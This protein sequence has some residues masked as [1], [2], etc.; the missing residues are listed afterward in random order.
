MLCRGPDPDGACR[1]YGT[2]PPTVREGQRSP[3]SGIAS[4]AAVDL[5]RVTLCAFVAMM[6]LAALA[7]WWL[8]L[9]WLKTVL[10]GSTTMKANAA[11]G[12]L[13]L[14]LGQWPLRRSSQ[15]RP[16]THR[17]RKAWAAA[18]VALGVATLVEY[19]SGVRLGIDELLFADSVTTSAPYNGRMSPATALGLASLGAGS[20]LLWGVDRRWVAAAHW[21]VLPAV[22]VGVLS[23]T[24]YAYGVE[25]MYNFGPY[26]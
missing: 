4:S 25:R 8:G 1:N 24:G 18:A 17:M 20:M 21:L 13:A 23:L 22:V 7:G 5:F 10:P 9:D 11:V 6:A 26:V 15:A 19:G 2:I 12:L 14:A 3:V 16:H